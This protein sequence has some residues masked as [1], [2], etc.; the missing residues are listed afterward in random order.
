MSTA[1]DYRKLFQAAPS[2][3][4]GMT[5]CAGSLGSNAQNDVAAMAKEFAPRVH[6]AHLRNVKREPDGSFFEADHLAGETDMV[7]LVAAL[8]AEE[9]R[10]REEG[11][12]DAE[13]PMRPDHGHLLG[14]DGKK[15]VNPGYSFIGRLRGLAELRGV[16]QTVEAFRS[17]RAA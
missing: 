14:D 16:M 6:F 17:G 13:I 8:M 2:P 12:A 9:D 4:N 5:L 11:R 7:R 3:A 10:R 15:R 1:E